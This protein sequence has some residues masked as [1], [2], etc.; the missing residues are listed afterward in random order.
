MSELLSC[1][2]PPTP[3]A[4]P[5]TGYATMRGT[6]ERICYSCADDRERAALLTEHTIGAYLSSD[7]KRIT[8]WTGGTLMHVT[9]HTTARVGFGGTTRHYLRA[10]DVHGA[11]SWIG[12]SPG[13]NMYARMRRAK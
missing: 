3:N 8:T 11:H 1:G 4:E 9:K 12:T 7:G 2:H 10:T 13:P 6:E 5:G